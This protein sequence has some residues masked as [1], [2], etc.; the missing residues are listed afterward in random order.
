MF[1]DVYNLHRR[2]SSFFLVNSLPSWNLWKW[3][4]K[5]R[6]A[7]QV[8]LCLILMSILTDHLFLR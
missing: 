3:N 6:S 5:I 1:I 2:P 7:P 4:L 8:F